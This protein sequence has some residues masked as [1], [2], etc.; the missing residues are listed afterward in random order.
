MSKKWVVAGGLVLLI[1]VATIII[2]AFVRL[3][4][5]A[6]RIEPESVGKLA[7][8]DTFTVNVTVENCVNVYAVQVDIRY[9]P[10]VLNVTNILE[11]SFLPSTGPT[12][13][14]KS[15]ASQTTGAKPLTAQVLFVDTKLGTDT[16]DAN[17]NGV[18]F[19]VTFKVLSD[20]SSQFQ[21]FPHP[22][23]TNDGTF[24][25]N[26]NNAEIIPELHNGSYS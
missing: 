20:G 14:V 24:F 12:I 7:V 2:L 5:T 4:T 3:P 11:G 8:G 18:L 25:E 10:Q 19:I 17:G 13:I 21:F 9:D 16:P 1:I 6:I 23:N 15:N 26:G 22:P